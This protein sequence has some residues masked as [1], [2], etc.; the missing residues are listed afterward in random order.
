LRNAATSSSRWSTRGGTG[1]VDSPSGRGSP[2]LTCR[3]RRGA[4]GR[5]E[6]DR[7]VDLAIIG[8]GS[9]DPGRRTMGEGK[10][11]GDVRLDREE[12]G[13]SDARGWAL[14]SSR[15]AFSSPPRTRGRLRTRRTS[16][17]G[18]SEWRRA[19]LNT[20]RG[21]YTI[22]TKPCLQCANSYKTFQIVIP[23]YR[24]LFDM[25]K[26]IHSC[27]AADTC[28]C[29]SGIRRR[30]HFGLFTETTPRLFEFSLVNKAAAEQN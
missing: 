16:R 9:M 2:P 26:I 22:G 28:L 15:S 20:K 4:P 25:C 3:R 18:S 19:F 5:G 14:L 30:A 29:H 8:I 21:N 17:A 13:R 27:S 12:R 1:K 10:A 24:T 6:Q 11:T 23:P 7:A